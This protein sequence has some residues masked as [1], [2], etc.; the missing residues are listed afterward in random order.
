MNLKNF[1]AL[2]TS[3]VIAGSSSVAAA[4][5][6]ASVTAQVSV[7]FNA[8]FSGSGAV[9]RDHR[10]PRAGQT[11]TTPAKTDLRT[12]QAAVGTFQNDRF[13]DRYENHDGGSR[14][15]DLVGG[16]V[17]NVYIGGDSSTY[18]GSL[19]A[20]G[21]T[22]IRSSWAALTEP[23]R[24]ERGRQFFFLSSAGPVHRLLLQ[25]VAGRTLITQV[26]ITYTDNSTEVLKF[27]NTLEQ[28]TPY[29]NLNLDGR[30]T[31]AKIVVYGGTSDNGSYRL[32]GL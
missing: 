1:K 30:R 4:R 22:A 29:L 12:G 23:T 26:A 14:G 7:G 17:A 5:P 28:R 10:D 21:S 20:I 27:G 9:V 16:S 31:V 19:Y 24:I 13:V 32:L 25:S 15:D 6:A 8:T 3:L 2:I 11:P 18:I